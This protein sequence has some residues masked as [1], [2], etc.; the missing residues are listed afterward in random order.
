MQSLRL[1]PLGGLLKP[2]ESPSDLRRLERSGSSLAFD[3][4]LAPWMQKTVLQ[5]IP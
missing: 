5:S 3:F 1:S 2:D 4:F